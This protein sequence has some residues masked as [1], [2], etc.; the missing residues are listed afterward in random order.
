MRRRLLAALAFGA[1]A[2]LAW[3]VP[4]AAQGSVNVYCSVQI[5]WCQAVATNFQRDTGIRVNMTQR[6]SGETL[7]AI[8][9]ES[10]NPRG[11]VWFGGTGDPH[12]AAAEENLT[13]SYTS[14]NNAQLFPWA[15]AQWNQ[16]NQRAIGVYAGAVGFG[17]N[18]ELLA[19][20]NIA[21]PACWADLVDARF[22]GEI[23]VANP[24]SSGTAYVII[25]TL[26]QLMGEDQAFDYMRRLH[27]NVNSYTRSGTAP[28]KAV[29]RGE[30]G[31]SLSFVHDAVTERNAGFPVAYST[32]CEGTGYEIGSMS[33]IRGSR[34]LTQARRFYDWA[35]TEPAQRLGFE[36]GGQLQQPSNR[37]APLPP[38]APDLSRIR[39]IDY[40][41]AKYGRSAERRRLIERWDREVGSQPR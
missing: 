23:Q 31:V 10:Q 15:L 7:A 22:R 32:P 2:P 33:I 24:N 40:D 8:R 4:A 26:V 6:G 30:T 11:D 12:L 34:N 35:L 21:P 5:E 9:A 36:A 27:P 14:P 39:L 3:S 16:S 1:A 18:T 17:Y 13:Q 25:A 20:K 41:F 19:R 37:S 29:A 38:N 28:I